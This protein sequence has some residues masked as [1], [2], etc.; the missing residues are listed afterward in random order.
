MIR[1]QD[2]ASPGYLTLGNHLENSHYNIGCKKIEVDK[3]SDC[4]RDF[5]VKGRCISAT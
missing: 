5:L 4:G 3:E 1:G 2:I